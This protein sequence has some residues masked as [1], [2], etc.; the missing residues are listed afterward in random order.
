MLYQLSVPMLELDYLLCL[1]DGPHS[2][3][4]PNLKRR[5]LEETGRYA[6]FVTCWTPCA[7][8]TA[9]Q[10]SLPNRGLPEHLPT[11]LAVDVHAAMLNIILTNATPA[12]C[13]E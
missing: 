11:A 13:G 1:R 2:C 3:M 7:R 9:V 4:I 8:A 12:D 10:S 5:P 6:I